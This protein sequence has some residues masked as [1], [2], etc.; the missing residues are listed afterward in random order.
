MKNLLFCA[1]FSIA[2]FSCSSNVDLAIDNPTEFPVEVTI[3]T[4]RVEVPAKQ[5]VWV[6]MGKGE[7]KVTLANDSIISFNFTDDLYMLNPT[8][9]K[10]LVSEQYYGPPAFQASYNHVLPNKTIEFLGTEIEG[11]Y[12]TIS[13]VINKVSWD[14]GPRES[15]PEMIQVDSDE[16]YTVLLKVSDPYEIMEQ[17][18]NAAP[19][20][21]VMETENP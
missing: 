1:A 18:M 20:E 21:E 8:Q 19:E 13:D 12:K 7:H 9:T 6:E 14:Y 15:L 3:D 16:M 17:Y 10:Y 11:N 4:L 5:V 2:L